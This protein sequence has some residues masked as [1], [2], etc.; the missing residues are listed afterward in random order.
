MSTFPTLSR[1]P[2]RASYTQTLAQDPTITSE[3]ENG[4]QL[5]RAIYS[6]VALKFEFTLSFLTVA[7]KILLENFEK[8]VSYRAGE[9]LWT[10]PADDTEYEVRFDN[11][12]KFTEERAEN[13][14]GVD[15]TLIEIRPNTS[16]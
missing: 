15:I 1:L 6:N 8:E 5:S 16:S 10:S 11:N 3:F 12:L 13:Y 14:W 7:D 4:Y 9:F 2:N